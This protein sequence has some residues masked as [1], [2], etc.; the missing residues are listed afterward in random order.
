LLVDR[1]N[2]RLGKRAVRQHLDLSAGITAC[3]HLN[4]LQ[5]HREQGNAD[6]LASGNH[7]IQF[8]QVRLGRDLLCQRN[9][10][11]GFATH[12]RNHHHNLISLG[13]PAFY[14]ASNIPDSLCSPH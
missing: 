14:P 10:T 13:P 2:A 12:R 1:K 3:R 9:Q 4:I 8:A 6:L 5:S 7:H 11:V